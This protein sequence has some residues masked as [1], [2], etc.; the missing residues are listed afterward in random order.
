MKREKITEELC[1]Q[2]ESKIILL[3]LDGLGGLPVKGQTAL[4]AAKT[5]ILDELA[6]KS[7]CGLT[8]PVF[9]GITPGSGP[10]HLS[11]FGY[12]PTKYM[13]GRGI[14]E[15]LGLGVEVGPNDVVARGNFAT[16]QG[17][18][19]VDRRAGRIQT[20]ENESLCRKIQ[21]S[22]KDIAGAKI[23]LYPGM[24]HRFVVKLSREGLSD[25]LTD[26]DPQKENKPRVYSR[27]LSQEA[28]ETARIITTLLDE[29]TRILQD[30]PKANTILLRGFSKS[31][32]LPKMTEKYKLNPVAIAH[33]PM[34]LGLA[35]LV[36]M[37]VLKAD[38]EMG[39]LFDTAEKNYSE[40]NFFY[41]HIKKPDS[42]GEDGDF[43]AKKKAIEAV[44]SYVSRLLNLHPDVIVV[45]SDHST[46]CFMKSHSWHPN[47]F[48]LYSSTAQPDKAKQ[49]TEKECSQG[50]LG[51][52]P[53]IY[54]MP[55]M[56]AH[57]GKLKK[58]G[59]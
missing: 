7:V 22:L 46:P 14:L 2:T 26:A 16:L 21:D 9:M 30:I 24:E 42:A 29:I 37:K 39:A 45:T 6:V 8:D 18:L 1:I 35:K 43:E 17:N 38:R 53:S 27:P 10:A 49:F 13:L 56:L 44:D 57:A 51:R 32:S 15:A 34:Y 20:R 25:M 31:P 40:Y 59:A 47:P 54:A 23:S 48:L 4:E 55:I 3:V 36:G 33:Y 11:L 50:Y 52:F 28:S 12:D 5:P 58:Y 19:I 41:I